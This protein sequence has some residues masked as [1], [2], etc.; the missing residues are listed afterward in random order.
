MKALGRGLLSLVFFTGLQAWSGPADAPDQ[1]QYGKY[2]ISKDIYK[3][4]ANEYTGTSLVAH[5]G[6]LKAEVSMGYHC[7]TKPIT[8]SGTHSHNNAEI[9]FFRGKYCPARCQWLEDEVIHAQTGARAALDDVLDRRNGP[10]D[11]M[12]L[13]IEPYP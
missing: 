7:V 13:D 9:L 10:G 1:S 5:N 3:V 6:E 12:D 11:D 8:F 2:I 4:I